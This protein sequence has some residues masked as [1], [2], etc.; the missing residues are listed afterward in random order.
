MNRTNLGKTFIAAT[1]ICGTIVGTSALAGPTDNEAAWSFYYIVDDTMTNRCKVVNVKPTTDGT[2]AF[3]YESRALA[4]RALAE[5]HARDIPDCSNPNAGNDSG[6]PIVMV[7]SGAMSGMD[8][9]NGFDA[10]LEAPALTARNARDSRS[11]VASVECAAMASAQQAACR[12]SAQSASA[13]STSAPR[14]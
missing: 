6:A 13:S 9:S 4:D 14:M 5:A 2:S 3:A 1:L 12:A 10:V 11:R 8:G 7:P